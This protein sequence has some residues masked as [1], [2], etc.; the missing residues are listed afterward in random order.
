[1]LDETSK[2]G[3]SVTASPTLLPGAS[4]LPAT[5]G[6]HEPSSQ[7]TLLC[8]PKITPLDRRLAR[9]AG[10][11]GVECT[12][13]T[14]RAAES[15][16]VDGDH[17]CLMLSATTLGGLL[18]ADGNPRRLM[19][20]LFDRTRH[21]L[22]YGFRPT[23]ADGS[24]AR[25]LSRGL[26]DAVVPFPGGH[27]QYTISSDWRSLTGEF[28]GLTFGP[29]QSEID[30]GFSGAALASGLLRP[31]VSIGGL[32][33][34]ASLT[35]DDCTIFMLACGDIVDLDA[36]V[37]GQLRVLDWFSRTI[38]PSMFIRH[39]F[40]RRSW[41]RPQ[42]S[43]TFII[44]DPLLTESYGFLN[45]RRLLGAVGDQP[46]SASIAFIPLNYRR[47]QASVVDLFRSRPAQLSLCV[48]GCD[49]TG[50]EFATTDMPVLNGLARLADDRMKLQEKAT[51]LGYEKVMVFPQG[52]F[53]VGS[54]EALRHNDF[55]AAVNTSPIPED[56]RPGDE[57]TVGEW[58]DV[59]VTRYRGV[60]LF[61]RRYPREVVEFAFDLFLGKPL[62]IVEHHTAFKQGY[63]EIAD[64]IARLNSLNAELRW[65]GLRE[66]LSRTY[67]RRDLSD[68]TVAARIWTNY[69]VIRNDAAAS[70]RFLIAKTE[71]ADAPI[72]RVTVDDHPVDYVIDD[73]TLR[74]AIDVEPGVARTIRIA[75]ANALPIWDGRR[76][77]RAR[78]KIHARRRLSEFRDNFLCKHERLLTLSRFAARGLSTEATEG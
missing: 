22:V 43:A 7:A 44:D 58:L 3:F 51:G 63:G 33:S 20:R 66:T 74:V 30:C 23:A 47:G 13:Q 27:H 46:F 5:G 2:S 34:F 54:L 4:R 73:G 52:R 21:L 41:R 72:R 55:V 28:S 6:G 29:I 17:H 53:S 65:G 60:P 68:D 32:P 11:L 78:L 49:H 70:T 26:V 40:G 62:L 67:M 16:L 24:T 38:P 18:E 48:H 12:V 57:L 19:Q 14:V 42:P 56:A 69:Q 31:V 8:F 9:L 10:F 39:A 37:Q 50:G 36:K 71:S 25:H 59:A 76:G 77:F 75:Y 15:G 64:F 35:I 45:Y 61:V 1:M